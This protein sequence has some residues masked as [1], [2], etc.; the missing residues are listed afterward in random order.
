MVLE[1]TTVEVHGRAALL[2]ELVELVAASPD[3]ALEL[4]PARDAYGVAQLKLTA[5]DSEGLSSRAV[6]MQ[7]VVLPVN[8]P[9]A[10][11]LSI[12]EVVSVEDTL[13][14]EVKGFA[15]GI[16]SGGEGEE[17]QSLVFGVEGDGEMFAD[18]PSISR[19]GDLTFTSA[20]NRNGRVTIS[21]RLAD[22]AS[23]AERD[24]RFEAAAGRAGVNLTTLL[25]PRMSPAKTAVIRVLAVNDPPS[26]AVNG[27]WGLNVS[28]SPVRVLE[29]SGEHTFP[30][31]ITAASAGGEDENRT[32][33]LAFTVQASNPL[34]FSSQPRVN[35]VTQGDRPQRELSFTLAPHRNGETFLMV[36]ATD[37]QGGRSSVHRVGLV[38]TPVN[39]PPLFVG[40]S[41]VE[42][43]EDTMGNR[44]AGWARDI[45]SGPDDESSQRLAFTVLPI[46]GAGLFATLP[47]VDPAT[48][49][50]GFE[51]LPDA[52]GT[53]SFNITLSDDGGT[54][55]GG[56]DTSEVHILRFLIHEVNDLPSYVPGPL[57]V[58]PADAAPHQLLWA[59]EVSPGPRE[60]ASQTVSFLVS[61][62]NPRMFAVHG[63][64]VINPTGL[65]S[66]AVAGDRVGNTTLL[67]AL[68]DSAGLTTAPPPPPP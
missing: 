10:F 15:T 21:V 22:T 49:D 59:R 18:P 20:A 28:S 27:T 36:H 63:Q 5:V 24:P 14:N 61:V 56:V 12:G 53:A 25:A 46:A 16:T 3:G 68:S 55:N 17:Q 23:P 33:H 31:F 57:V 2:Q 1:A 13:R 32:Q 34:L 58:V 37:P 51:L 30:Y 47:S 50:L 38:V 54:G 26:I 45:T 35:I 29:D 11:T 6:D 42:A 60:E 65:L 52:F 67:V 66:F 8:D 43:H 41:D 4:V 19:T 9:P 62:P 48:G 44:V 39:D 7:L 64:P 40:G